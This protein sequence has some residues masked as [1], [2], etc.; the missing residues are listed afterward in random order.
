MDQCGEHPIDPRIM[1]TYNPATL[2][3]CVDATI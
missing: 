2:D 3:E 1:A